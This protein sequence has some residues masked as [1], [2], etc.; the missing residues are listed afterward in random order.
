[1]RGATG[2]AGVVMEA[3][4]VRPVHGT[5]APARRLVPLPDRELPAQLQLPRSPQVATTNADSSS[6]QPVRVSW[7]ASV[8]PAGL[9]SR[10]KVQP[11]MAAAMM[12][13]SPSATAADK[14]ASA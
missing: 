5:D 1:M 11:T 12:I 7:T 2:A 10:V 14:V 3:A 13:A 9:G 8:T 6:A 4:Q